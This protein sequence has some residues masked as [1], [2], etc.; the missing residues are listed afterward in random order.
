MRI[1]IT[2]SNGMLGG[3][4]CGVLGKGNEVFGLDLSDAGTG[5]KEL[6]GFFKADISSGQGLKDIF[7]ST[8]PDVVIHAAAM[9]DV[10]GCERYKEKAEQ[11]NVTGTRNVAEASNA[12]NADMVY[13]STDFVF[14]GRAS[15]PYSESDK[16][17]PLSCY[18][19]TKLQGEDMVRQRAGRWSIIR[20]S[21]LYGPGGRNFVDTVI[22][23]ACKEGELKV[24]DDQKGSPTLTTDL[25]RALESFLKLEAQR[26]QGVFHVSNRGICTWFEF[27]REIIRIK[28]VEGVVLRP[29]SSEKLRRPA[30]RPSF[31]AMSG[32]KFTQ[33]TGHTMPLWKDALQRYLKERKDA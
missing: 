5:G 26:R 16:T 31:S 18:G 14:G 28:G 7:G 25:A 15:E 4:L 3:E 29:I 23:K 6:E 9:T 12:V 19:R 32:D 1:L 17:S 33:V 13:I 27:S 11:I 22:R 8:R 10:D 24:V 30:E 2:G 20:T 21:W